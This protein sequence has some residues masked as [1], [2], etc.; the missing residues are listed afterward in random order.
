MFHKH[1]LSP[2]YI[3][4][5]RERIVAIFARFK[6]NATVVKLSFLCH[7]SIVKHHEWTK[8]I[9]KFHESQNIPIRGSSDRSV[10]PPIEM[11]N[12]HHRSPVINE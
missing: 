11:M 12:H 4:V 7:Y 8:K 10:I 2:K 1:Q 9:T 6:P 3:L 5:S